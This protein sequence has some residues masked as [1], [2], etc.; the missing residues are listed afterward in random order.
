[1]AQGQLLAVAEL[2]H[3]IVDA[4]LK[5]WIGRLT[6]QLHGTFNRPTRCSAFRTIN[7]M[8]DDEV[9]AALMEIVAIY[10]AVT[11]ADVL[12]RMLAAA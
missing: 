10:D 11:R 2:G 7:G 4:E 5:A 8:S 6:R 1:M 12:A 9:D 3:D